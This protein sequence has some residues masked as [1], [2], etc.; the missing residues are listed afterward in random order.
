[1]SIGL[2]NVADN[3]TAPTVPT[4]PMSQEQMKKRRPSG[5][6]VYKPQLATKIKW[7]LEDT[8]ER[9]VAAQVRMRRI[10]AWL[11]EAHQT[12]RDDM[13][14]MAFIGR[15]EHELLGLALE[16]TEL[17]RLAAQAVSA[18]QPTKSK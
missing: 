10:L 8:V 1:M 14:F 4:A 7:M 3:L 2:G 12:R 17:E 9:S 15:V 16:V 13:V 18:S 11:D 5:K 6:K